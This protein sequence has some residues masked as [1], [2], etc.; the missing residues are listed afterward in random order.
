MMN[1][2]ELGKVALIQGAIDGAYTVSE[3]ARRLGL[4]KR[5]VKQ[6]KRQVREE[7]EGSVIHGNAGKHPANYTDEV[8]RQRI[9]TL[10]KSSLYGEANFTCFRELLEEREDVRIS[11][12]T[13]SSILKGA[14]IVSRRKHRNGGKKFSR[15]KRRGRI[16]E[17]LQAD[18]TPFD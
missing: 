13:L 17:L 3:A 6:L 11:Y 18:A 16:G 2:A 4:S 15:R 7:G 5:R 1:K 12:S 9:I 14:G 10:K 8:L